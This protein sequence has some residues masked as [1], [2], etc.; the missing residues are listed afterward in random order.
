MVII[1]SKHFAN[2]GYICKN[3]EETHVKPYG[4]SKYITVVVHRTSNALLF[5]MFRS[6]VK[7]AN[8]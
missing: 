7:T 5:I 3:E 4:K 8:S 2:N 1:Y 6:A